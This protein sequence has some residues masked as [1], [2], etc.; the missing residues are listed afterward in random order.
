MLVLVLFGVVA[1]CVLWAGW[2][3]LQTRGD[4]ERAQSLVTSVQAKLR[5]GD[6]TAAEALL[7]ELRLRLDRSA[8]RTGDPAWRV[9][10]WVPLL[11]GN[12]RS[13]RTTA[14]AADVL[15]TQ[16][17]PEAVA[18]LGI[19]RRDR[20]LHQGRVNLDVLE[21]LQP[22]LDRAVA[23]TARAR[24]LVAHRP[25]T[26]LPVV[27]H[28]VDKART[29]I[30]QLDSA[31]T[32]ADTALQ[33]A[34]AML[35]QQG[36]RRYFIAVQNDA[37]ARAT[38]G[39]VGA[40]AL[41]TTDRGRIHLDHT[42]TDSEFK[43]TQDAVPSD[44]EASDTWTVIGSTRAWYDA[45][46]TPH[47]PDAA[48]NLAGLWTRQ[49]R[50]RIDGVIALDPLVMRELLVASG[51][52]RLPD[53][54]EVS[55]E[56]VVDFVERGEYVRYPDVAR[57]KELLSTL[58]GDLFRSVI[59]AKDQISTLQAFARA[60][61]S[62]HLFVWS[63]AAADARR[64]GEAVVGGRLPTRDTPYLS[65]LTQNF[66]GDKLDFYLRRSV[67]VTKASRRGFLTVTTALRNTA[68][69]GLPSYVTVRS[70]KPDPPVPYGQARSSV[71]VYGALSTGVRSIMIDGRPATARFARDHG[72][73]AATLFVEIPRG[74]AVTVAVELSEPRGSLVYRQQPLVV[75]DT[76][77]IRVPHTVVGR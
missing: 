63:A 58:A 36:P 49:S 61:A 72:H 77:D 75:P 71:S 59:A 60:G 65:V 17:V 30:G 5:S 39:L 34:P 57:R 47:F 42:G 23:A 3:A 31:L 32:S 24:R 38:G 4:L 13:I 44:A 54:F 67:R 7:P 41:V 2:R 21:R 48:R 27:G 76:L 26:L 15:G 69:E 37:E 18:V 70:D 9:A 12:F 6:V 25:T 35:G 66:G 19:V 10:E 14:E 33:V 20:P 51:P 28:S 74:A 45:N 46:L 1:C 43:V 56:N 64:L 40:F 50:Q 29:R 62:G 68:P 11:G 22:H 16:A 8:G 53:G 55:A 52:V 73:Q